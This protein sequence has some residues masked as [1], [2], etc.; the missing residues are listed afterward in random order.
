M[1]LKYT[2]FEP[3]ECAYKLRAYKKY[4]VCTIEKLFTDKKIIEYLV[5]W[6]SG[7]YTLF[8]PTYRRASLPGVTPYAVACILITQFHSTQG[9]VN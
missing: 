2:P 7:S 3:F 8:L 4:N 6:A 1:C 9:R 5:V